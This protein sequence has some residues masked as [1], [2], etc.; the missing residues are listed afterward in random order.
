MAGRNPQQVLDLLDELL[1]LTEQLTLC[2][3]DDQ[4]DIQALADSCEN[5]FGLLQIM[6][7]QESGAGGNQESDRNG[8]IE[9][10]MRQLEAKA[11][12]C[13][14]LLKR[15]MDR[16]SNALASLRQHQKVSRAYRSHRSP[17]CF[18]GFPK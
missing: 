17:L 3:T 15:G 1:N 16:T 8:E 11:L 9:Q 7:E 4:I 2:E 5:R 13:I 10:K 14:E 6:F 18:R 12:H